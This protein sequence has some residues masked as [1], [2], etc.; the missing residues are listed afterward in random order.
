MVF[1]NLLKK[2][3][4]NILYFPGCLTKFV[5]KDLEENYKKILNKIGIDFIQL[6]DLEVC[7]GS[8]IIN[9]GHREEAKELAKKNY[10]VFKSH[11]VTKIITNCPAC[12]YM[13]SKKYPELLEDWDIDV[14][15][16]TQTMSK[17]IK[18]NKLN[19]T[20]LNLDLTYHD[21]CH[22][23]RSSGI[24][25][26]PRDIVNKLGNLKEMKFSK[27]YSFCCGG[28]SGVKSNFPDL[29]DSIAKERIDMAKEIKV[30]CLTTSC[31]MCYFHLKENSK[32]LDV[33]ELS[34]LLVGDEK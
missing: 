7:C 30:S 13:F 33:K 6:K 27:N 28:G 10:S 12:Y 31:P 29:A 22:L 5:G 23:G 15:H 3:N 9:S 26:E 2:L 4:S 34:Q 8:P 16:I 19:I 1:K 14:E 17:A 11:S 21:P 24:Y 20:K 32:D 25:Q 18:N